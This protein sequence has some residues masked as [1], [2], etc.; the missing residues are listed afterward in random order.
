MA[1]SEL[2]AEEN[3]DLRRMAMQETTSGWY[4]LGITYPSF[5]AGYLNQADGQHIHGQ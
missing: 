5:T 4:G 2:Y 1:K 3:E